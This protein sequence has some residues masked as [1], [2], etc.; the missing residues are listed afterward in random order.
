MCKKGLLGVI[1]GLSAK[2]TEFPCSLW[3]G[4]GE[5]YGNGF[6]L[7]VPNPQSCA[8]ELLNRERR[9]EGELLRVKGALEL[10]L[11]VY[12]SESFRLSLKM[13]I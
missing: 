5:S 1:D 2:A 10:S 3:R 12:H 9:Y 7:T 6:P 4:R 13:N 11:L 8:S